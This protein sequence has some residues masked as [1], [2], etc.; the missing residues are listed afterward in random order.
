[1]DDLLQWARVG[2]RPGNEQE[3]V[4]PSVGQLIQN[5]PEKV[6]QGYLNSYPDYIREVYN[7]AEQERLVNIP[8]RLRTLPGNLPAYFTK[9]E[10]ISMDRWMQKRGTALPK[11]V[12]QE[13]S[14]RIAK[15]TRNEVKAV[16]QEALE[17]H[18]DEMV[19]ANDEE[20]TLSPDTLME[21]TWQ[22][23]R[24]LTKLQG[25]GNSRAN[26]LV[27]I[28]Y[29]QIVPYCSRP[30]IKWTSGKDC[31]KSLVKEDYSKIFKILEDIRGKFKKNGSA[32][33]VEKVAYVLEC[34]AQIEGL[35]RDGINENLISGLAPVGNGSMGRVFRV[36]RSKL[37]LRRDKPSPDQFDIAIKKIWRENTFIHGRHGFLTEIAVSSQ[38]SRGCPER[39]VKFLGWNE[40]VPTSSVYIAMEHVPEGDLENVLKSMERKQ[41]WSEKHMKIV[42]DQLLSGLVYMHGELIAHRDLKPQNILVVSIDTPNVKI[43]D[44]G[45]SKRLS[46][47]NTSSLRT[48]QGTKGYKAP[49]LV[50]SW[51][52]GKDYNYSYNVDVWSLGCVIFRM[53][54]GEA[55]FQNDDA[56]SHPDKKAVER[57]V[58]KKLKNWHDQP[59]ISISDSGFKFIKELLVVDPKKRPDSKTA[60]ELNGEWTARS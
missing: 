25:V 19:A 44:F 50:R 42:A 18:R 58:G 47:R 39:F 3:K 17:M 33:N 6:F 40:D 29:P 48:R 54:K 14:R 56:V 37:D 49:E 36:K 11:H 28:R 38:L 43:A 32:I 30:L 24:C 31:E 53:A 8:E 45:V 60:Q 13:T 59:K 46:A 16:T 20:A 35:K 55:L 27:S 26:L 23:M 22:M 51:N 12:H 52:E 2:M 10:L 15:N 1:M 21:Y 57:E 9:E 4:H 5:L 34:N 7:E 41:L